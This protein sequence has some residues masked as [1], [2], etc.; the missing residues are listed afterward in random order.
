M[1]THSWR[2][3]PKQSRRILV[4]I[5]RVVHFFYICCDQPQSNGE[6]GNLVC[7]PGTLICVP[8]APAL[9]AT[10][11]LRLSLESIKVYFPS[12]KEHFLPSSSTSFTKDLISE[13]GMSYLA[14][15]SFHQTVSDP[16][17]IHQIQS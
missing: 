17:L 1:Q 8:T 12:P 10:V 5:S 11:A 13:D 14:L 4:V 2:L 6:A 7:A 9:L 16:V 15:S 3:L